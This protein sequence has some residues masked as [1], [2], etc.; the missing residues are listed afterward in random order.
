MSTNATFLL[1]S[2]HA[3][4][5]APLDRIEADVAAIEA[6]IALLKQEATS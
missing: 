2:Y 3:A 1:R 4:V 5:N 6:E